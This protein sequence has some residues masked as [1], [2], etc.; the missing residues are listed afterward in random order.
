MGIK[1]FVFLSFVL[2]ALCG[3]YVY[4]L[5]NGWY[6]IKI[7]GIHV[8]LPISVWIILPMI[9]I[10]IASILHITYYGLK[11]FWANRALAKDCESF[12]LASKAALL[13]EEY[14]AKYKT[15]WFLLPDEML[16]ALA[17]AKKGTS[18]LSSENLKKIC[19]DKVDIQE[20]KVVNLKQYKLNQDNELV[21]QNKLNQLNLEPKFCSEVLRS[22]Q[23]IKSGLCK[24]AFEVL[25]NTASYT[26]IKKF[27]FPLSANDIVVILK[28]NFNKEDDLFISDTD[29]DVQ[30]A[31][32]SLNA[33]EYVAIAQVLKSNMN[34]DTLVN[35][36]EKM[37]NQN[38]A[39]TKAYIYVLFELQML[40]KVRDVLQNADDG[41]FEEFETYLFLRENGKKADIKHFI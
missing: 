31:K 5:V 3:L 20:G 33:D 10:A 40:D 41:E 34:P 6:L 26:E 32:T 1:R 7:F 4:S 29:I 15:K 36:F 19:E 9:V 38:H 30:L 14:D 17:N 35:I 11:V 18:R 28:R 2:I 16:S 23:D 21:I 13:G 27:N 22:C 39:A 37:H 12:A 24:K 8:S 25:I